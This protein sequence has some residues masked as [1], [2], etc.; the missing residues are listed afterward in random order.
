[1][2]KVKKEIERGDVFWARLDPT[3]G[4][5]LQKTRPV[6]VLTINPLNKARKTVVIVPL[7]TSAPAIEFLNVAL[8]GGSVARCEHIRAIDKTRLADRIGSISDADMAKIKEGIS[9]ILGV[10]H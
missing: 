3:V 9:R 10:N 2:P 4:S 7:S 1:M 6:V 8:K 5:E